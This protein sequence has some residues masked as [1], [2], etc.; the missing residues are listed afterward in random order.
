MVQ[1]NSYEEALKT[2]EKHLSENFSYM[3]NQNIQIVKD[4]LK[5]WF[6]RSDITDVLRVETFNYNKTFVFS[7]KN[8]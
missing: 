8:V 4:D 3:D 5:K 6:G 7:V 1:I 2:I